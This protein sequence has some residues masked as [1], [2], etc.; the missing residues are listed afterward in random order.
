MKVK[1]I[2][3]EGANLADFVAT[4]RLARV[5]RLVDIRQLPIS[6]RKG[7]AK[8]A[9]S[10][11]L[12]AADIEYVHLRGLGDPK[13][14][15]TAARNGEYAKFRRIFSRHMKSSEA[16]ADLCV[17]IDLL[18]SGSNCLMCFEKDHTKCHRAIVVDAICATTSVSIEHLRVIHGSGDGGREKYGAR[19]SIGEGAASCR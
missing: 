13:E 2:G 19:L 8:S 10:T 3:Y 14:G 9:L 12:H 17:A 4:L 18:R 16:Q 11:A 5:T 15:R 6:R 1:T 7:F